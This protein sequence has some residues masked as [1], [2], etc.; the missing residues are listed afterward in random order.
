VFNLNWILFIAGIIVIYIGIVN[1]I[2]GDTTTII[3]CSIL[4]LILIIISIGS[5]GYKN[6][7]SWWG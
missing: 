4:L 1:G 2:A 7:G 3:I 5:D 6:T